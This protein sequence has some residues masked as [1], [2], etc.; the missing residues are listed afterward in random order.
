[1]DI[2]R[3]CLLNVAG[4][5][6]EALHLK[7]KMLSLVNRQKHKGEVRKLKIQTKDSETRWRYLEQRA[8]ISPGKT[9]QHKPVVAKYVQKKNKKQPHYV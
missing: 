2:Y 7:K 1:M 4:L 5:T 6:T 3:Y 9:S 8:K